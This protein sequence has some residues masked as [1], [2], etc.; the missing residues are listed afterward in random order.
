MSGPTHFRTA[1]ILTGTTM[2]VFILL[3][4]PA[5][6]SHARTNEASASARPAAEVDRMSWMAGC[7]EGTLG[8]GASYEEVWLAPR[9]GMMLGMA[10]M[11][12]DG[13]T[14]SFEFASLGE[15]DGAVVYS[16]QPS[17][18][19]PTPFR[20]KE[21]SRSAATFENPAH[22]FPQRVIY[23]LAGPDELHARIEGERGGQLRG[24]DF[25]MKRVSCPG[26]AAR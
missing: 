15:Q 20:A 1:G 4:V 14:L 16:A 25:P 2:I 22:D 18:R 3:A 23:R 24:M 19:P 12:R 13:R 5:A 26:A 6:L 7:W 10:R 8:N 17:G 9:G 21:I 11:S